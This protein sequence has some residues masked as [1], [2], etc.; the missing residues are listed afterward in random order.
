VASSTSQLVDYSNFF[1]TLSVRL[2]WEMRC[3]PGDLRGSGRR[4]RRSAAESGST[5]NTS[6]I[7][8]ARR[9]GRAAAPVQTNVLFYLNEDGPCLFHT[10]R[11]WKSVLK[12]TRNKS[13]WFC[14]LK[15]WKPNWTSLF[16]TEGKP[17]SSFFNLLLKLN[18]QTVFVP[19]GLNR[20]VII[21]QVFK[22]EKASFLAWILWGGRKT[23]NLDP[24]LKST[25]LQARATVAQQRHVVAHR[26]RRTASA[27]L[28]V[29]TVLLAGGHVAHQSFRSLKSKEKP[30][31]KTK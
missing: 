14:P 3:L 11:S 21:R 30:N 9:S 5:W 29:S 13:W 17:F 26:P 10:C 23:R 31:I 20:F 15:L 8:S 7:A 28:C 6:A 25:H 19:L 12:K 16:Y 22:L 1:W 4:S 24:D 2:R 27:V 18:I